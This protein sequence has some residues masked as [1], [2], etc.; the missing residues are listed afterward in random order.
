MEKP[1]IWS[2]DVSPSGTDLPLLFLSWVSVEAVACSRATTV[3]LSPAATAASATPAAAGVEGAWEGV[4]AL[5][6]ISPVAA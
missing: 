1:L 4:S 6:P 3:S 2:G 5:P